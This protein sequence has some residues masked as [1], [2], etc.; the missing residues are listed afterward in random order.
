MTILNP[1][2]LIAKRPILPFPGSFVIVDKSNVELST[3]TTSD[4][5]S[6]TGLSG[7]AIISIVGGTY[8]L[9]GAGDFVSTPGVFSPGDTFEV[10]V[11]SSDTPS[12]A[13]SATITINGVSSTFVVTTWINL[14]LNGTFD[15]DTIW[16]KGT[17]WSIAGG[18]AHHSSG[19]ASGLR[20]GSIL[21]IGVQYSCT[22]TILNYVSNSV[23]PLAGSTSG[24]ARSA[25]GT[26][27][28]TITCAGGTS[29]QLFCNSTFV[30]DIDN[31]TVRAL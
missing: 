17:G 24:T 22:F 11:T 6:V 28:E 29:F 23:T 12:T 13:V 2:I 26:Y 31:V 1:S 19:T 9:N 10:Q 30:S 14:A 3:L 27:T 7:P 21:T 15:S 4:P 5:V 20:Q 16:I 18:V 8:R 25:N